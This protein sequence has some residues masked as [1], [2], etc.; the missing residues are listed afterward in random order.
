MKF[1]NMQFFCHNQPE[2]KVRM[3][4]PAEGNWP[5]YLVISEQNQVTGVGLFMN[6]QQ[7]V[8]FRDELLSAV[9]NVLKAD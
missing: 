7:L 6:T 9:D 3:D 2:I 5:V 4:K 8:T 1:Y